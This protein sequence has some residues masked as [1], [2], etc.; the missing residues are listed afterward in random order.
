MP[1]LDGFLV[2][3][4]NTKSVSNVVSYGTE[5]IHEKGAQK[6][7][8]RFTE[9]N[10]ELVDKIYEL[11]RKKIHGYYYFVGDKDYIEF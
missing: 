10:P 1:M 5:G 9:R 2:E 6:M 3:I 7:I 8:Y 4:K 11:A